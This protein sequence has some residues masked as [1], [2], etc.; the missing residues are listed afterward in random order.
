MPQHKG[1]ESVLQLLAQLL[2]FSQLLSGFSQLLSG[3]AQL[4]GDFCYLEL[5]SPGNDWPI[6]QACICLAIDWCL[7]QVVT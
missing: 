7:H 3:C 4:L 6:W 2:L 1:L 5:Q